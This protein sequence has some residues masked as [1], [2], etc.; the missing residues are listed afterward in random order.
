MGQQDSLD[1][2]YKAASASARDSA[3]RCGLPA[4]CNSEWFHRHML[5]E[6]SYT[7]AGRFSSGKVVNEGIVWQSIE[8]FRVSAML[9]VLAVVPTAFS[10]VAETS[11]VDVR[12]VCHA[13][14]G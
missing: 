9:A 10:H 1:Q 2:V 3:A 8:H 7:K 6:G 12:S 4:K 14:V 13:V 5:P 11:P